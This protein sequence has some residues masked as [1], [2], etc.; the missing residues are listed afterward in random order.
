LAVSDQGAQI[1]PFLGYPPPLSSRAWALCLLVLAV[2]V[3][4]IVGS[5]T[6]IV[7]AI[8]IAIPAVIMLLKP[9]KYGFYVEV[10]DQHL[11]IQAVITNRIAFRD[12]SSVG[13]QVPT[14]SRAWMHFENVLIDF[15]R[16]FGGGLSH[17]PPPGEPDERTVDVTFRR[18]LVTFLPFPPFVWPRR[19]WLFRVE[20][21]PRLLTLI[22]SKLNAPSK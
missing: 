11:V 7:L 19:N 21:A 14:Y 16:L 18:R 12:I 6:G 2:V 4:L 9:P 13:A 3:Q 20:E 22:Q 8:A 17:V 15:D 1:F 5:T 10:A